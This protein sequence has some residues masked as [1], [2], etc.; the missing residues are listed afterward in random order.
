M[1]STQLI[2]ELPEN[3][4]NFI[5]EYAKRHHVT[6]SRLIDQYI[7]QI[8]VYEKYNFHPDV[9]KNIG[10]VPNTIDAKKEYYEHLEG[11]HK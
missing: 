2:I 3:D 8:Q 6:V 1:D 9:E 7:K 5:N 11:K 10:I 4:I